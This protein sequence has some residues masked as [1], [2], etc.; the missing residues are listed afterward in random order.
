MWYSRSERVPLRREQ[1]ALGAKSV[2][3]A[4]TTSRTCIVLFLWYSKRA[5]YF[6][7]ILNLKENYKQRM[8][9]V[10]VYFVQIQQCLT[11]CQVASFFSFP[12]H[13]RVSCT[14]SSYSFT[15]EDLILFLKNKDIL[16]YKHR[17][18]SILRKFNCAIILRLNIPNSNI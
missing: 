9:K 16:L 2:I 10:C 1:L 7:V 6:E 12:N 17:K 5:L 4:H 15:A 18:C 11:F 3:S 14:P 8:K 13:F